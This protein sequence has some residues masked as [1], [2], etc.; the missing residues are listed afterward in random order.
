[1]RT[2]IMLQARSNLRLTW[3]VNLDF[4]LKFLLFHVMRGVNH[5]DV[6]ILLNA[7]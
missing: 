6:S 7:C 3:I 4:L 2:K 1:M 5:V